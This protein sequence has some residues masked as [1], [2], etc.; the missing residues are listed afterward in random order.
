MYDWI[1]A[2]LGLSTTQLNS[3]QLDCQ[4]VEPGLY[5]VAGSK[6]AVLVN[7]RP[8]PKDW[9]VLGHCFLSATTVELS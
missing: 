7:S 9:I 8:K 2:A 4:S 5:S 6:T 3:T 1:V